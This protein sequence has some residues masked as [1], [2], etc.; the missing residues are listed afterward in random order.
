MYISNKNNASIEAVNGS[1]IIFL[2]TFRNIVNYEISGVA[3]SVDI[4][5]QLTIVECLFESCEAK[6]AGAIRTTDKVTTVEMNKVCSYKSKINESYGIFANVYSSSLSTI[7]Y[8]STCYSKGYAA[9][10]HV[11]CPKQTFNNINSSFN[12]AVQEPSFLTSGATYSLSRFVEASSNVCNGI[13]FNFFKCDTCYGSR[14]NY[15]NCTCKNPIKINIQIDACA[16][17]V[18]MSYFYISVE[19][20]ANGYAIYIVNSG[21]ADVSLSNSVFAKSS[22]IYG[23]LSQ[24]SNR[25][26]SEKTIRLSFFNTYQ[27]QTAKM[28][29][30]TMKN[31]RCTDRKIVILV[32]ILIMSI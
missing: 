22:S 23:S 27:C 21:N 17:L 5:C 4:A 18:E 16:S 30:C 8:L 20:E 24:T 7:C 1:N 26:T 14:F 29:K 19:D 25:E 32:Q 10:T 9:T 6:S 15:H 11:R 28:L 3:I 12:D 13:G 31:T 2:C